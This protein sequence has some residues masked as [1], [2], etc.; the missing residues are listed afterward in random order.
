V[1]SVPSLLIVTGPRGAGKTTFCARVVEQVRD[2]P[3]VVAGILSP[4]VFERGEKIGIDA[5]DLR[6]GERRRLASPFD[7]S[8]GATRTRRWSF[9]DTALMWG[10]LVL[11]SAIPCDLLIVDE[12]GI[13]ELEQAQGWLAGL[14]ALDSTA[15]RWGL[16]VIRPE[17]LD[18]A[19][20]RWPSARSLSIEDASQAPKQADDLAHY[21]LSEG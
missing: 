12:L 17:L 11:Q 18:A 10:N 6:T 8:M 9:H 16:V 19:L 5:I 7:P 3:I 20:R 2:A 14:A 21:I 4:A 15:Y 1:S 13:L